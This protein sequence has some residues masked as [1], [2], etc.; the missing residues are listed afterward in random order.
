MPEDEYTWLSRDDIL[1]FDEMTRLVDVFLRLGVTKIRLTGGEP[2]L[3][4]DLP[5]FVRQLAA[6]PGISEIALTSN[7]VLLGGQ[8]EALK[9]AGLQRV[10]ISLD[11]LEPNR[12]RRLTLQHA[13]GAVLEA[14][15][16]TCR[17]LPGTKVDAVIMRGVNDDEL[18]NLIEYGTHVGA[19]IRFIEYM[20]VGGA[21]HWRPD[22]VVSRRD[23]VERLSAHYGAIDAIVDPGT[24]APASEFRLPDGRVFGII[25]STTEPFCQSCGRARLTADGVFYTCLY[26]TDGV[27]LREPLRAGVSQDDL[28]TLVRERWT[29]RANRG[30]EV[31]HE[32]R[33]RSVFLPVA[34]LRAD[35][36]L[37]MHKRGG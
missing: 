19:E 17:L 14:I 11:T 18:V 10:N 23:I 22:L 2:L 8:I 27:S 28:E 7:G 34:A 29:A 36:H 12:F 25:S 35:P 15:Q 32:L 13:H 3:R 21:T 24:T 33:D 31:R 4:R 30:A 6:R 26:A 16:A 20:D 1:A 37:E 9:D 5:T